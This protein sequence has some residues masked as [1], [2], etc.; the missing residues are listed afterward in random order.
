MNPL[1]TWLRILILSDACCWLRLPSIEVL[2]HP[3]LTRVGPTAAALSPYVL[4]TQ[5]G[6]GCIMGT[7][8]VT[9]A[10]TLAVD[11]F[12]SETHYQRHL[13]RHLMC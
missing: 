8:P 9:N 11:V 6:A 10:L 2:R 1:Y 13:N 5:T 4:H 12:K 3:S 7:L